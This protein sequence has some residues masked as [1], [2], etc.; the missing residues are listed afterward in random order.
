[1]AAAKEFSMDAAAALVLSNLDGILILK[2]QKT[3]LNDF[4]ALARV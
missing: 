1:M 4:Q 3:A 2:E